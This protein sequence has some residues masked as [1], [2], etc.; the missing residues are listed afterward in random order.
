MYVH[1]HVSLYRSSVAFKFNIKP[2]AAHGDIGMRINQQSV[3]HRV[4]LIPLSTNK[5]LM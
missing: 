4:A 1:V 2:A 3:T 5:N